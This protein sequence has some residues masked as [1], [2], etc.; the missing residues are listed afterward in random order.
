ML[1]FLFIVRCPR[2]SLWHQEVVSFAMVIQILEH[3]N[4]W[5]DPPTILLLHSILSP[6]GKWLQIWIFHY[7]MN[8]CKQSPTMLEAKPLWKQQGSWITL[9]KNLFSSSVALVLTIICEMQFQSLYPAQY[10]ALFSIKKC[11]NL[12]TWVKIKN[13]F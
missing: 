11:D 13:N 10:F 4:D 8:S 7:P 3:Y 2:L 1:F 12:L 9:L 6:F 5:H